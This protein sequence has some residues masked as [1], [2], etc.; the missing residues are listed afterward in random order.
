MSGR[1][2]DLG[3]AGKECKWK[4]SSG[5]FARRGLREKFYADEPEREV[6]P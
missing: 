1:Y 5:Y 2:S 3:F 6:K 4:G